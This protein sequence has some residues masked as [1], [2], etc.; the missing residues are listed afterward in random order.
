MSE[1]RFMQMALEL[2][3]RG[4]GRVE[5]NPPVGAVVVQNGE[6]VGRGWHQS[7]GGSH[8][9]VMALAE[10]GE[11]ARGANLFVTLEPCSTTGKTPPCTE[12]VLAAGV[13]CVTWAV[14]D[15]NPNHDGQATGILEKN[16]IVAQSGTGNAEALT[17]LEGFKGWLKGSRPWVLAKWAQTRDGCTTTAE[18]AS[19]WISCEESRVLV[20]EERSRADGILIGIGTI[21]ADDPSLTVRHVDGPSPR[22]FILDTHARSP[23]DAAVVT[24]DGPETTIVCGAEAPES[25][26]KALSNAGAQILQVPLDSEGRCDVARALQK[27]RESGIN[28]LMVEGGGT[29]LKSFL[30]A[31]LVDWVQAYVAPDGQQGV[32]ESA[33]EARLAVERMFGSFRLGDASLEPVGVDVCVNG[34]PRN[35]V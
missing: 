22:R 26:R 13:S 5:P 14:D 7:F 12:A 35:P 16:G 24:D 20:H 27:L 17:L 32:E 21:L 11:K 1:E 9:E 10:A 6:V 2:A 3:R 23:L 4:L 28:R 18:G 33:A 15:P 29:V 25:R 19:N 31:G 30:G 8:A 34:A